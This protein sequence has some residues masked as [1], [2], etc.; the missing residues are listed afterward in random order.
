MSTCDVVAEVAKRLAVQAALSRLGELDREVLTLTVWE[1]LPPREVAAV[2]RLSPDVVRTRLSRARARLR[3]L[4]CDDL[5]PPGHV[6]DVLT[7][8]NPKE[9]R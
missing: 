4:V 9:D 3:A 8:L 5:S 7:A 6:L 1:G 2:L